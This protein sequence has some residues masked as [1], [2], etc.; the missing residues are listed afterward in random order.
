MTEIFDIDTG[1]LPEDLERAREMI[2]QP[3]RL[4]QYNHEATLDTIR[5]YAEGMGDDNP[6]WCDEAYAE[7]SCY[8]GLVAPP[9][10]VTS[11]FAGIGPGFPG[12]HAFHG[13]TRW[14]VDRLVR[15]GER[16]VAS[17]KLIG[18][19]EVTGRKGG[20]MIIETGQADYATLEGE[21]LATVTSHAIRVPRPSSGGLRY[22]PAKPHR[23]TEAEIDK[24]ERHIVGQTR[25]GAQQR[26]WEDVDVGD[27]LP[28]IIKGPLD[29]ETGIAYYAGNLQFGYQSCDLAWKRRWAARHQP[30]T[31]PNVRP[32]SW[33]AQRTWGGV[34]HHD[35][36]VAAT[37]GMPAAYDNGWCRAAWLG[38]VVTDWAGDDSLMRMHEGR[39]VLPNILGDTLWIRGRVAEKR[40]DAADHVVRVELVATRQD[41]AV[42]A[43]GNAEVV[44][45]SAA[46]G[47]IA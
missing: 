22:E 27:E 21:H 30:E 36:D 34:G 25:R 35:D 14:E 45:P 44:L 19:K 32:V 42:S 3:L 28:V 2:G 4:R 15:R 16:V 9:T 24:I 17:A 29:P 10:W 46:S 26:M 5:H 11:V 23:Y 40:V 43:T 18:V 12:I 39:T 37:V 1:I 7:R 6:L 31:V 20:S 41:G 38:Q 13:T 33:Y 8:G 47:V